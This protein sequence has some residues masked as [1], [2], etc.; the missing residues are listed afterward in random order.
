ML[1]FPFLFSLI[2]ALVQ[3][4]TFYRPQT[5]IWGKISKEIQQSTFW[6][7]IHH[8]VEAAP[9]RESHAYKMNGYCQ[10]T[11]SHVYD[12]TGCLPSLHRIQKQEKN[13]HIVPKKTSWYVKT[14]KVNN[15]G[16]YIDTFELCTCYKYD[17]KVRKKIIQKKRH[18]F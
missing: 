14:K 17:F 1:H 13:I 18:A 11:K 5:F 9:T 16:T 8:C 3:L 10:I 4:D 12:L 15:A 6:S 2:N 7:K